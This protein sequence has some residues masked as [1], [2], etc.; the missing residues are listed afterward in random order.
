MNTDEHG[1]G[2]DNVV[3]ANDHGRIEREFEYRTPW[4]SA[5]LI[6]GP[7]PLLIY[8]GLRNLGYLYP[9]PSIGNPLVSLGAVLFGCGLILVGIYRLWQRIRDPQLVSGLIVFSEKELAAPRRTY[10]TTEACI[11]Y[12]SV[13][14]IVVQRW[15]NRRLVTIKHIRGRVCIDEATLTNKEDFEQILDE[16]AA[17]VSV[18]FELSLG[19]FQFTLASLLVVTTVVAVVLGIIRYLIPDDRAMLHFIGIVLLYLSFLAVLCLLHACLLRRRTGRAFLHWFIGGIFVE[20]AATLL[21]SAVDLKVYPLFRAIMGL[22]FATIGTSK[23]SVEL[24]FSAGLCAYLLS[25][26]IFGTIGVI[27]YRWRLRRVDT[28]KS[29]RKNGSDWQK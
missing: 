22:L 19:R 27:I 29:E 26:V 28:K 21:L 1:S 14:R 11:P 4:W 2:G 25:G 20:F 13:K 12:G 10:S 7:G 3:M 17:R 8:L 6:A 15:N 24:S 9:L 23:I 18:A 16:L 5:L